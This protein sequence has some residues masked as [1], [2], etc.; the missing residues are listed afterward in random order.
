MAGKNTCSGSSGFTLIELMIVLIIMSIMLA[1]A[2]PRFAKDL[3]SLSLETTAKK[4]A[5]ALRYARSQALSTG[6]IYNA[7]FDCENNRVILAESGTPSPADALR[8]ANAA[9]ALEKTE[10][11]EGAGKVPVREIK[12]YPL[13]EEINLSTITIADTV[14]NEDNGK[15]ICQM[16]FYPDGTS[17][18]GEIALTDAKDRAYGISVDFLTGVVLLEEQ[19]EK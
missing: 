14:C 15:A 19:T 1:F 9:A 2:A 4:V 6:H 5:G 13:P 8:M 16:A 7:I 10:G 3:L 18:G 11:G 17:Q 12:I